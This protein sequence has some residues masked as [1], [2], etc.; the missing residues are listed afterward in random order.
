MGIDEHCDGGII[1]EVDGNKLA[2][3]V[4]LRDEEAGMNDPNAMAMMGGGQPGQ[5]GGM[6]QGGQMGGQQGGMGG[7]NVQSGDM[8][9]PQALKQLRDNFFAGITSRDGM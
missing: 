9:V 5:M 7:G 1:L 8:T 6:G 3:A 4:L 2:S